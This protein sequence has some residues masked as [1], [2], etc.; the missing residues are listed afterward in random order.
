MLLIYK[1]LSGGQLCV[2]T[3][4][5][6]SYTPTSGFMIL[7]SQPQRC[8]VSHRNMVQLSTAIVKKVVVWILKLTVHSLSC[9]GISSFQSC[10]WVPACAHHARVGSSRGRS[11]D[12]H[13][14]KHLK[15]TCSSSFQPQ[16]HILSPQGE[17]Q[18]FQ[19]S[20][21]PPHD[22]GNG[23]PSPDSAG[24]DQSQ[25]SAQ[26]F[27]W[28]RSRH[29]NVTQEAQS[30]GGGALCD[31]LLPFLAGNEW[32][33]YP[34]RPLV[35]LLR[36]TQLRWSG[37]MGHTLWRYHWATDYIWVYHPAGLPAVWAKNCPCLT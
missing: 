24:F 23:G 18:C 37:E 5:C 32:D 30:H 2:S 26:A 21:T 34:K 6:V 14:C 19:L 15:W 8:N 35:V 1:P 28:W 3:C 4:M 13:T 20:T 12:H 11:P 31:F 9:D 27:C 29:R 25:E 10:V 33:K 17:S 7:D 16:P 36:E 22:S